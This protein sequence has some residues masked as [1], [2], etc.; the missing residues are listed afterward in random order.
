MEYSGRFLCRN[1][2]TTQFSTNDWCFPF[3]FVLTATPMGLKAPHLSLVALVTQKSRAYC[4]SFDNFWV[5]PHRDHILRR[6][7]NLSYRKTGDEATATKISIHCLWRP[8]RSGCL[9]A[10]FWILEA[11]RRMIP[12]NLVRMYYGSCLC[13]LLLSVQVSGID[14]R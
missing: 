4:P 8:S 9:D 12:A 1:E 10:R 3:Q 5:E 2:E 11:C 13:F 7:F 6:D 14:V